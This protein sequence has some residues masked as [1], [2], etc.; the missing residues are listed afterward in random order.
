MSSVTDSPAKSPYDF[1]NKESL[2]GTSATIADFCRV[3]VMGRSGDGQLGLPTLPVYTHIVGK[4]IVY[5]NE[6]EPVENAILRGRGVVAVSTGAK[7]SL[8]LTGAVF[9]T[10]SLSPMI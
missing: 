3:F 9:L 2:T 10:L 1:P 4:E 8:A 5:K 6:S 7:H